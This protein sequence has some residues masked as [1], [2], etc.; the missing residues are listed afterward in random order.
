MSMGASIHESF[1]FENVYHLIPLSFPNWSILDFLSYLSNDFFFSLRVFINTYLDRLQLIKIMF[2]AVSKNWSLVW[3]SPC[4]TSS[5]V[6]FSYLP[7]SYIL[8]LP[9]WIIPIL[10]HRLI[11]AYSGGLWAALVLLL[12]GAEH[13]WSSLVSW[14]WIKWN[15]VI[16]GASGLGPESYL[17]HTVPGM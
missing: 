12:G 9:S 16:C 10:E 2:R 14:P 17:L 5:V 15:T 8:C 13:S 11:Q 1:F 7:G 3:V 4:L 6:L